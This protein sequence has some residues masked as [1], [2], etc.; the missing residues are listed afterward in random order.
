MAA[1]SRSKT[2]ERGGNDGRMENEENPKAVSLVSHRPWKSLRDFHISTAP[3]AVPSSLKT[4]TERSSPAT[5]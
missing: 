4:K 2:P 3:T 5:D 1:A